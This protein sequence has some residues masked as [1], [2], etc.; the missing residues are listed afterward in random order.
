ML[1]ALEGKCTQGRDDIGRMTIHA[2]Q[3]LRAAGKNVGYFNFLLSM[4]KTASQGT[5]GKEDCSVVGALVWEMF[6]ARK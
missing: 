4:E 5:G 3:R 1:S 6:D 2:V